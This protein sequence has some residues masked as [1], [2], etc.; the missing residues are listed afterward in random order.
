MRFN[1]FLLFL[2]SPHPRAPYPV[3]ASIMFC[4]TTFKVKSESGS[5]KHDGGQDRVRC[6]GLA[7]IMF[8][9]TTFK[10]KS[11]SV[12]RSVLSDSLQ[13]HGL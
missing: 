7:S 3:L 11:E 13:P 4:R 2:E 1:H 6:S 8:C 5:T 10:V 12:S 9:R